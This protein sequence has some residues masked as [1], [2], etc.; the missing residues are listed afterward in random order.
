[1]NPDESLEY[2]RN[3]IKWSP[4]EKKTARRAFDQAYRKQC[5]SILARV[6][7]MIAS[8]TEPP[9]IWEI[10]D[11]LSRQRR[12]MDQT[13]DYRYSVLLMVFGKLFREKWLTEAD[14][15]GLQEGKIETIRRFAD[16]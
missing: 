6:K 10:H 9:D 1:M 14:L 3:E 7:E 16:F 5:A 4:A 8:A 15:A 12:S 2:F 13:Y 11:Y